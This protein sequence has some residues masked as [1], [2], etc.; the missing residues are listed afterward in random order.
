MGFGGSPSS[1]RPSPLPKATN[2]VRGSLFEKERRKK[3]QE[4]SG[5]LLSRG[6]LGDPV[7]M[8]SQLKTALG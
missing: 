2:V 6:M 1:R 3:A 5:T 8:M 7:L 4:Q